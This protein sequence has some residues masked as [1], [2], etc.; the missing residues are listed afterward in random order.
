MFREI[1]FIMNERSLFETVWKTACVS[2]K[3]HTEMNSIYRDIFRAIHEGRWLSIEYRNKEGQ[4]SRY[5]IGIYDLNAAKR[6]LKVEGLHLSRYTTETFDLIYIDSILSSSIVEGSYCPVNE[7]LVQDIYLN[8]HKY[9][10]LFEHPVNL[11]ILNYLEMCNRMDAV[12]YYSDF[13]L[14]RFLDRESFHGEAYP[15][16]EEQFRM[17]VKNFQHRTQEKRSREG[18]LKLQQLAM[19][20]LS[21]HT[22]RGLYVLAYR[23]LQLDVKQRTLRPDDEIVICTEYTLDGVKENVRKFLDA[24]EYDLLK[25]FEQ[26]QELIKE[27]ITNHSRQ[28]LGVDDMPYMIGLGMD[29]ILDLHK[30]YESVIEMYRKQQVTAPIRAFFGEMV[31]K[32]IRR[33]A[34]PIVLADQKVNLDQLLAI[35]NA[36]KYPVAYIQGPPGTGKTSTIIN[37]IVTAFFNEKTVLFVSY[38]NHPINGV[39]EKLLGMR[40]QDKTIPFPVL[41]L[42]N[43]E[44]MQ[45]ALEHIRA[46]YEQARGIKVYESTLDRNRDDRIERAKRLSGLLRRYEELLDLEE[47]KET[48]SRVLEYENDQK[49]SFQM[50]PFQADLQGRQME[51]VMRR[52][53]KIG[54]TTWKSS[55][56]PGKDGHA[57]WQT[58]DDTRWGFIE[59]EAFSLLDGNV[60]ELKKYLY[61]TSARYIKKIDSPRHKELKEIIQNENKKARLE[62]FS[63]YLGK[64]ENIKKL[65]EIFPIV[66]TTC[67]SAHKLGEPVSMFDMVIMDEASQCN[68]AVSLVPIL[69]GSS[70]MMVG[71]PQQLNPV[72]QLEEMVNQKLRKKYNISDEYDYRKNSIYK[73]FLACDAVSD[74]ILLHYHYR[75]HE[76]IIGFNNKKYYNEKLCIKTKSREQEPLLY[77]DVKDSQSSGKNTAPGEVEEIINYAARNKD[78][79]I[80]V[81]TPFV[82]QKK[83]LEEAVQKAHLTNVGCGTVHAFQGDEKD[84]VLFSTALTAQTQAGT[85]EWLKNNKE[86]INV[87]TSRARDKLVILS[88]M[89]NLRRLHQRNGEDDLYELVQYTKQNGKSQVTQKK[90]NSR[91]LGVKPFSSA[92]EEAFLKNLNHALENIWLSQSRFQVQYGVDITAV[93]PQ[94]ENWDGLFYSQQFDFVVYEQQDGQE[95]P[96]LAIELGGREHLEEEIVRQREKQKQEICQMFGLQVIR[97]ENS[98][99]RRYNHIKEILVNFFSKRR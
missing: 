8:P 26:N 82:N 40:Y 3:E 17:I 10:E 49:L 73:T 39:V 83:L 85:Y 53:E 33:K 79:T 88:D 13:E 16:S 80:G 35:N 42:G 34:Y 29:I 63:R 46:V 25:D 74:E 36:M 19:N 70:L 43:S 28:V 20:V 47:R 98:Y 69:R 60:E 81:I 78:K 7:E 21:I 37:T 14:I 23:K 45:E 44:K 95:A 66:A 75:C 87:A 6:T 76:K 18:K 15:L 12:P 5:W 58:E 31:S 11:K 56:F 24:E 68:T 77:I 92:T 64:K 97:V 67:I 59:E 99:A 84:I 57:D 61:Y 71:D 4:I 1:S 52:M 55:G 22:P 51:Q 96:V 27:C 93:L 90:A 30:E 94:G 41:R 54:A 32:P 9:K 48:I 89:E 50:L 2:I 65:Q 62:D 72:I 91:A 86:L 38:N